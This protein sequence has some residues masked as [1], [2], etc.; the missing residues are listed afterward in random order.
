LADQAANPTDLSYR[1]VESILYGLSFAGHEAVTSLICNALICL[2]PHRDQWAEICADPGLIE[3]A[4][5]EVLRY[6]SSQVSWRRITTEPTDLA[7]YSLPAGTQIFMNLAAASRQPDL[8]E[9]PDRFDIHRANANAHI[10][11]GKGIHYCLGANLA[12][13]ETQIVL[14]TLAERVPSIALVPD[15]VLTRFPNI[16]FR[17]PER[18]HVTWR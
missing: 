12:K 9:D 14:E 18:L 15:Q 10:P 8:F 1:E 16:T 3:N 11:F 17:G 7:G 4:V 6:E 2:L 13:F 5:D